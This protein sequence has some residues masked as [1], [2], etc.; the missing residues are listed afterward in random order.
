MTKEDI[1]KQ[2]I[3]EGFVETIESFKGS[4]EKSAISLKD[5]KSLPSKAWRGYI[6]PI[7]TP[8]GN[9]T[10]TLTGA[11]A[12]ALTGAATE[13]WGRKTET[14]TLG[15]LIGGLGGAQSVPGG[16]LVGPAATAAIGLKRRASARKKTERKTR[17][18]VRELKQYS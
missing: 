2:A 15:S 17:Q 7:V 9:I 5:I 1:A 13:P 4:M 3:A 12:G 6:R 11:A 14:A 8:S 18:M 10:S 16:L